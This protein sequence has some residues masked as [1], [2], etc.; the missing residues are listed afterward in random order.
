MQDSWFPQKCKVGEVV[1]DNCKHWNKYP[2]TTD[3]G[4]RGPVVPWDILDKF[5]KIY[6]T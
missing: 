3:V 2:K 6:Y 1:A 4:F 5:D